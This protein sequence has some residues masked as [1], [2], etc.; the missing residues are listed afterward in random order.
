MNNTDK[1]YRIYEKLAKEIYGH[2]WKKIDNSQKIH[3]MNLVKKIKSIK[4]R[5]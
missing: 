5:I 1:L 3:I 2:S 4:G